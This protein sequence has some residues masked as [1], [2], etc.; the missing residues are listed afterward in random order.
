[1]RWLDGV[2]D[3]MDMSLSKLLELMMDREAWHPAVHGVTKSWTRLSNRTDQLGHFQLFLTENP[4]ISGL[5]FFVC[6]FVLFLKELSIVSNKSRHKALLGLF[7]SVTQ[8]CYQGSRFFLSFYFIIFILSRIILKLVPSWSQGS[9]K[10]FQAFTL[11]VG[12]EK[13]RREKVWQLF[14]SIF[15]D[16]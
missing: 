12:R 15:K 6:L 5:I 13:T 2:I 7:T 3:P 10:K 11:E 16:C 1:M 14:L 9:F 8:P 4:I